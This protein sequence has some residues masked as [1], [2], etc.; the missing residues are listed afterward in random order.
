MSEKKEKQAFVLRMSTR[1]TWIPLSQKENIIGIGWSEAKG[2]LECMEYPQF[3]E[4]IRKAYDVK[5]ERALGSYAGS[6]WRFIREIKAGDLVVVPEAGGNFS[7]AEVEAND[8]QYDPSEEAIELDF[9]YRRKVKWKKRGVSR[10]F[11]ENG[12]RRRMKARQ[13]CVSASD[14]VTQIEDVIHRDKP[15]NFV[16]DIRKSTRTCIADSLSRHMNDEGLEHLVAA[17]AKTYVSVETKRL[18]KQQGM[19]GDVDV[20]ATY[21]LKIGGQESAIKV[22]YQVKQH[23]GIS[24][25][26]G[27]VQLIKRMEADPE[28]DRCCFVTTADS[29]DKKTQILAQKNDIIVITKDELVDWVLDSDLM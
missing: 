29:V 3:K 21:T 28:I 24:N 12:L 17:L 1:E 23:E 20:L 11:A 19:P 7:V 25:G 13:T 27:V 14:L 6:L 8:A 5:N 16:D 9:C 22:A 10:S 2:L 4:I 18:N 15:I 26:E